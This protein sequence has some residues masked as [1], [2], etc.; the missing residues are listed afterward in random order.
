MGDVRNSISAGL[1]HAA[2]ELFRQRLRFLLMSPTMGTI[3]EV[4]VAHKLS[5]LGEDLAVLEPLES[6]HEGTAAQR[7][8]EFIAAGRVVYDHLLRLLP[9]C[10]APQSLG[11]SSRVGFHAL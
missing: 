4:D 11:T 5:I 3:L 2:R 8:E 9:P 1:R 7:W 10:G 6:D